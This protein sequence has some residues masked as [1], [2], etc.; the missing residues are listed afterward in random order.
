MEIEF[1]KDYLKELYEDGKT[2]NKK[3]R[4]QPSVTKQLKTRLINCEMLIEL[5]ICF[6]LKV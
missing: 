5:R 6:R 3:Y 1:E 4:F 2:S